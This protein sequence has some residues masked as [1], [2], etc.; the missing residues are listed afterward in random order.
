MKKNKEIQKYINYITE[1]YGFVP[2]NDTLIEIMFEDIKDHEQVIETYQKENKNLKIQLSHYQ[3][4]AE[5]LKLAEDQLNEMNTSQNEIVLEN[6]QLKKKLA[7]YE[8][9]VQI[10]HCYDVQYL[11][12]NKE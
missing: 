11:S 5:N 8:K 2:T 4:V 10:N 3:T 12:F 9:Y 6:E 1:Q 7:I